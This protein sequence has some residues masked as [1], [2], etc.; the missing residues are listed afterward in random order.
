[1]T[2]E[3]NNINTDLKE[4]FANAE[5]DKLIVHLD[6]LSDPIAQEI[7]LYNYD[8]I[9][10]YYETE[11]FTV[12]F[13]HIK[14]VAY[15]SFLCDYSAKRQLIIPADYESMALIFTNIYM[16]LKERQQ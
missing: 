2:E 5:Y 1:M 12:I 4:L 10:N 8:I 15:T 3:I 14:F 13:Q 16:L 11:K 6:L 7:T 9:K